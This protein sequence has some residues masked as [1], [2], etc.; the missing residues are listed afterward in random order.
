MIAFLQLFLGLFAI[1]WVISLITFFISSSLAISEHIDLL[2]ELYPIHL[3]KLT[4][5]KYLISIWEMKRELGKSIYPNWQKESVSFFPWNYKKYVRYY[6]S[7][8][9]SK[10]WFTHLRILRIERVRTIVFW[11][12]VAQSATILFSALLTS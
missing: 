9:S 1:V 10:V 5:S 12:L 8:V 2:S 11:I 7:E 3:E 6:K 4:F